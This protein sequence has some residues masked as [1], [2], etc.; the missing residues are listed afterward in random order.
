MSE[1]HRRTRHTTDAPKLRVQIE[2]R[3]PLP[4]IEGCGN[5]VL[6][7]SNWHVAH[8][9]PASQGGKTIASNVGP[10][11]ANCNLK[12]GGRLGAATVNR[13]KQ[14]EKGRRSWL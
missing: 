7:G 5:P 12:A 8:I 13:R 14:N 11:H 2:R 9:V 3:L 4:C 1:H 10:A 6:P